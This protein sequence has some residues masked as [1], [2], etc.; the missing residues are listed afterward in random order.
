MPAWSNSAGSA[1]CIDVIR[2]GLIVAENAPEDPVMLQRLYRRPECPNCRTPLRWS[3]CFARG[4]RGLP[5]RLREPCTRCGTCIE[6]DDLRYRVG[7]MAGLIAP[8]PMAFLPGLNALS[9]VQFFGV[10]GVVIAGT[11]LM[12]GLIRIRTSANASR[13]ASRDDQAVPT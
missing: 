13:P 8:L 10:Y 1:S 5:R 2:P 3:R 12:F 9:T 7:I 4:A 6:T 11:Q